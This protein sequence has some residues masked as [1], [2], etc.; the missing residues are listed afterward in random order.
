MV[1][2]ALDDNDGRGLKGVVL[3]Y[4]FC[5]GTSDEPVP[6]APM[7]AQMTISARAPVVLLWFPE[8]GSR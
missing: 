3:G 6:Q 2:V 1:I 4:L 8:E 5:T 7:I